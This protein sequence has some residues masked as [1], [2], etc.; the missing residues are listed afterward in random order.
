MVMQLSN[1]TAMLQNEVSARL[2]AEAQLSAVIKLLISSEEKNMTTAV[3]SETSR[4]VGSEMLESSSRVAADIV[5]EAAL[6]NEI[7]RAIAKESSLSNSVRGETSR[8]IKSEEVA[9]NLTNTGVQEVSAAVLKEASLRI[10]GD[11]IIALT[12]AVETSTRQ[13]ADSL[14]TSVGQ[15]LNAS[16][17][18]LQT[19]GTFSNPALSCDQLLTV[20]GSVIAGQN[21]YYLKNNVRIFQ[22]LCDFTTLDENGATGWTLVANTHPYTYIVYLPRSHRR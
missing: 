14:L 10:V 1:V 17:L 19:I 21:I 18:A 12:V 2:A 3:A 13:A 8:A 4:A 7:M 16:I 9:L 11:N 6:Q 15:K 20:P 22:A 5:Q